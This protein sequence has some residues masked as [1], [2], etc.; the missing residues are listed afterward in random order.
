VAAVCSR[1]H[2]WGTHKPRGIPGERA[3]QSRRVGGTLVQY[4]L[5]KRSGTSASWPRM[6]RERH[7]HT[8]K[9]SGVVGIFGGG[10]SQAPGRCRGESASHGE[11]L[12]RCNAVTGD[13]SGPMP[14]SSTTAL[15]KTLRASKLGH[16]MA[17][18]FR[19]TRVS[20]ETR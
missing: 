15:K 11:R 16:Y 2:A 14:N 1:S 3:V 19:E 8:T 6:R 4:G 10:Y 7:P 9:V 20:D 5:S 12:W 17:L 18:G 13:D